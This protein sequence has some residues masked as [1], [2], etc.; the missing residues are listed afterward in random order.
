MLRKKT[1]WPNG[2]SSA[3]MISI[4]LDGEFIWLLIDPTNINRP[5]TLSMGTYGLHRGLDRL[6]LSLKKEILKRHFLFLA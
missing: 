1:K 4:E 5:K 3:G 2:S 6:L